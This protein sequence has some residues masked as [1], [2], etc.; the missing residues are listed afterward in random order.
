[1]KTADPQLRPPSSESLAAGYETSGVNVKA[2]A[3]LVIALA[4]SA[5]AIHAGAWLVYTRFNRADQ[6]ANRPNSLISAPLP[7]APRIQPSEPNNT[8][9]REDLHAMYAAEDQVFHQM[10]WKVDPHN[11]MQQEIPP[12]VVAAVINNANQKPQNHP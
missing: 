8:V 10:G 11:P 1:M 6:A 2:L 3:W 12:S 4:I 9:D 7:P 5:V